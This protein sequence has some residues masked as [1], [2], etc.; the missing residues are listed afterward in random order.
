MKTKVSMLKGHNRGLRC[1]FK[2][3]TKSIRNKFINIIIV[4]FK[5]YL[6][7]SINI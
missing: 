7:K 5:I 6:Q 2:A 1:H 4:K 3:Y